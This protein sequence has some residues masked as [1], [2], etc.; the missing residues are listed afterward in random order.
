MILGHAHP[1]VLEAVRD[2]RRQ[3][4]LV[5]H[6]RART[7][8]SSP[9]RSS[10]RVEPLEQVRLVSSGTEATMS[11]VRLARGF[12]GR[13]VIVKFAGC[14][15]GH[16]DALLAAAGLGRRH[17]RAARLRRCPRGDGGRHRSSLPYNDV[18]ALEA[19]FA[20]RGGEIA[21]VITEAAA[22]NMGVVPPAPGLHRGPAPHHPRARRAAHLR[23]GHDRLPLQRGRVVRSRGPVC[24]WR[25]RPVHLRQGHGR[26]LP[27]RG[28]R[29]HAPRS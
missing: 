15:H 6:A 8:C 18:A 5:R 22:G 26:R 11:A 4:L 9:R 7:R 20:A 23:R 14:Y 21:A 27:R 24:R 29:W 19:A 3:G 17:P 13:S 12:T 25:T 16:V 1:D 28:L 2:G 10:R